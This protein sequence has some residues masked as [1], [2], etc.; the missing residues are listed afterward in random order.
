MLAI[1]FLKDVWIA[2][3][4]IEARP[5]VS[6]RPQLDLIQDPQYRRNKSTVDMN[7]ALHLYNT[8]KYTHLY[9]LTPLTNIVP[10]Q[11]ALT[12]IFMWEE[13]KGCKLIFWITSYRQLLKLER[14]N[15]AKNEKNINMC[16][17][18]KMLWCNVMTIYN[19][20]DQL[21]LYKLI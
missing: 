15:G 4:L 11:I 18:A 21:Q 13:T 7:T 9:S 10:F 3:A 12:G 17:G 6:S 20:N 14:G 16:H 5:I 19:E 8:D 2:F 1:Y